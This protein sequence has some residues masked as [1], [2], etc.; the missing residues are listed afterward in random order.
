[1]DTRTESAS[2]PPSDVK[3]VTPTE[4]EYELI[5]GFNELQDA[6]DTAKDAEAVAKSRA[7][8]ASQQINSLQTELKAAK[9]VIEHLTTQYSLMQKKI[10]TLE[11]TEK[12]NITEIEHLQNLCHKNKVQIE[13]TES[14]VTET[15]KDLD[16]ALLAFNTATQEAGELSNKNQ[17]LHFEINQLCKEKKSLTN[18]LEKNCLDAHTLKHHHRSL[19]KVLVKNATKIRQ[20]SDQRDFFLGCRNR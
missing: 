14:L 7:T 5:G 11:I 18:T 1:M 17:K 9:E 12:D 15:T 10:A 19:E 16:K 6:L 20:L 13:T 4:E 2:L 8:T 3:A